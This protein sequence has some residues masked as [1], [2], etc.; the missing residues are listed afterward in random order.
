MA[1]QANEAFDAALASLA[2]AHSLADGEAAFTEFT[3]RF[4]TLKGIETAER[5]DLGEAIW[6]LS[7]SEHAVRIGVTE[8]LAQRWFDAARDY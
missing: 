6:Q 2:S 1:K 8:E 4:N 3:Q 7:R 5:E